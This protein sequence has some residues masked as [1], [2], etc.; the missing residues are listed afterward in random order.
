MNIVRKHFG[1]VDKFTGDGILCF[2]PEFFCG[3]D[4]GYYALAPLTRVTAH[5][6]GT[7]VLTVIRLILFSRAL[8]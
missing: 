2:F 7:T 6:K 8:G 1:V 5:F 3:L 4:A